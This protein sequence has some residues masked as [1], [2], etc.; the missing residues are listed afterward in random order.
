MYIKIEIYLYL[1]LY[2]ECKTFHTF[3]D[4]NDNYRTCLAR[5][6]A[7]RSAIQNES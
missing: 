3:L 1:F 4:K 5:E 2:V 6:A 7:F